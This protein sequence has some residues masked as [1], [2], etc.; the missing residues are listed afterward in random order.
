M[1]S[2]ILSTDTSPTGRFGDSRND[3]ERTTSQDLA[4]EI[5]DMARM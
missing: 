2:T 1:D 4:S 5:A 3:T